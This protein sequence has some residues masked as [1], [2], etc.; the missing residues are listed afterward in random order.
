VKANIHG[1][2]TNTHVKPPIA[3]VP[4]SDQLPTWY[5]AEDRLRVAR[6]AVCPATDQPPRSRSIAAQMPPLSR[7]DAVPTHPEVWRFHT[8]ILG[9]GDRDQQPEFC[10]IDSQSG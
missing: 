1:K 8:K 7:E 6:F 2:P 4:H 10:K 5:G 3:T 9:Q